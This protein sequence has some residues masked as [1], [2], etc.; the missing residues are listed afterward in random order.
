M[1]MCVSRDKI[2]QEFISEN[3]KK[4][5]SKKENKKCITTLCA[6]ITIARMVNTIPAL[7]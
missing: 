6:F 7:L 3:R 1:T 2:G 4:L 5:R